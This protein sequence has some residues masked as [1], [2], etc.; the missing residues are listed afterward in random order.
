MK[1]CALIIGHKK[2]SPGASNASSGITEFDYNEQLAIDIE[3]ASTQVA[4]QRVYRR[5]YKTLPEDVNQLNPD[6]I[7]SLHCNAFNQ[8]ASGTEVLYYYRS[9]KGKQV[10]HILQTNLV[11]ALALKD[12]GIKDKRVENRGGFLLKYTNAPCVISEPFF[13]DNDHDLEIAKSNHEKLVK[14]HVDAI[15][16]IASQLEYF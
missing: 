15:N 14:A 10:A 1:L 3:N 13:I 2:G 12:R 8:A 4:V 9:K 5:T 16:E 6:F 7:I 11:N